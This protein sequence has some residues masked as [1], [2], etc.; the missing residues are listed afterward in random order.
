MRCPPSPYN[1]MLMR[2]CECVCISPRPP[3][4]T[5]MQRHVHMTTGWTSSVPAEALVTLLAA[6]GR[7]L[8]LTF[9][10]HG[11]GIGFARCCTRTRSSRHDGRSSHNGLW[12]G[13]INMWSGNIN[14]A[15]APL[16]CPKVPLQYMY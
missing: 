11:H 9:D 10:T 15:G 16:I 1:A 12:S 3:R 14:T 2:V 7:L 5:P 8:V 6:D 13:N 4:E